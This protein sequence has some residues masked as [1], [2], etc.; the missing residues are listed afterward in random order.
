M[1]E[2]SA[3]GVASDGV[4]MSATGDTL[5]LQRY[6]IRLFSDCSG[7]DTGG[8]GVGV[9]GLPGGGCDVLVCWPVQRGA[10]LIRRTCVT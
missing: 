10:N 7:V 3:Q 2:S 1:I 8:S 6:L 9:G 4:V 5:R